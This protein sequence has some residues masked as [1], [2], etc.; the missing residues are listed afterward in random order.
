[1]IG[2]YA[3]RYELRFKGD[4]IVHHLAANHVY[5]DEHQRNRPLSET[6]VDKTSY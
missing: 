3:Q 5:V 4:F 2:H 1:M 6:V